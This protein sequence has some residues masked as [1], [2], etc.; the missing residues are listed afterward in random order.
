V[1]IISIRQPWA[2]LIA[3]GIKDIENRTWRT[4][5]RGPLFVH[6]SLKVDCSIADVRRS[7]GIELPDLPVLIGGIVGMTNVVDCVEQHSSIWFRGPIGFVLS[8]SR[9][10]LFLEMKG[11]LK[12]R[13]APASV[14]ERYAPT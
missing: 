2:S 10:L 9:P 12:L 5:Y 4:A 3:H 6:A 1:K 13:D 8:G 7:L 11:T 14:L